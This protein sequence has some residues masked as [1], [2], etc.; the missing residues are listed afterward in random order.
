MATV[1]LI[2]ETI[3][4]YHTWPSFNK[5]LNWDP[6]SVTIMSCTFANQLLQCLI[7]LLSYTE[8]LLFFET[9][10]SSY[11]YDLRNSCGT[12]I[13][14]SIT[15][16][17]Y[18]TP[19][20]TCSRIVRNKGSNK[21]EATFIFLPKCVTLI[22]DFP[23]TWWWKYSSALKCLTSPEVYSFLPWS[24]DFRQAGNSKD[25][26]LRVKRKCGSVCYFVSVS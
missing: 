2:V 22:V 3:L 25:E 7:C 5:L 11:K 17:E 6:K 20:K 24:T 16:D 8:F 23:I 13:I 21:S 15:S 12:Q 14:V 4:Y 26:S 10:H 18:T 19:V 1:F 9:I